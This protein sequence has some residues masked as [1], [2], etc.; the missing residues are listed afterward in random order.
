M[1]LDSSRPIRE[2]AATPSTKSYGCSGEDC[3]SFCSSEW[4]AFLVGGLVICKACF[5]T[6]LFEVWL[7]LPHI[8]RQCKATLRGI[9][10][11]RASSTTTALIAVR[12][13][14]LFEV[15]KE[16]SMFREEGCVNKNRSGSS[17]DNEADRKRASSRGIIPRAKIKTVKMTLV[18][19][20]GE[21]PEWVVLK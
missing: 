15:D 11:Y 17:S 12:E 9:V 1:G 13:V 5:W 3:V 21:S 8:L 7:W 4:I 20:F 6:F 2:G 16:K 19:V 14:K 18:I 10:K